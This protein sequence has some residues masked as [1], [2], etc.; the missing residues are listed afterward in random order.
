MHGPR[1]PAGDGEH[2]T[3]RTSRTRVNIGAYVGF[4][5]KRLGGGANRNHAARPFMQVSPYAG[6]ISPITVQ[7]YSIIG[8]V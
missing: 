7:T 6:K 1:L 5:L 4:S 2:D 3:R 8:P